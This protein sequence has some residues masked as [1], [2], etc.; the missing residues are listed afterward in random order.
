MK[1]IYFA[2]IAFA[3][4]FISVEAAAQ[5]AV[6]VGYNHAVR[7]VSM[8]GDRES[9]G[10]DGFYIEATYGFELL[11]K[12]WGELA[13]Q[14]GLRFS[15]AGE[16]E[17]E[18][19]P[20]L[21]ARESFNETYLDI[22][23]QFKY[24]YPLGN[25]KLSAFAGPVLSFGLTSA[26]KVSLKGD[27]GDFSTKVNMYSDSAE[28]DYGRFDMKLGLGLGADLTKAIS[29]KLGYNIGLLNRYTGEQVGDYKYR[30]HTGVF[31]VGAAY[32]F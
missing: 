17:S 19:E 24:S 10:L 8:A 25:V 11:H 13:F 3:A 16:S 18:K 15:Y 4:M 21:T 27:G 9:D 29:L 31:Y 5:V 20:G 12:S 2:I 22:P 7:T 32:S 28:Y 23:L 6:G 30:I 14:P 1:R 26:Y